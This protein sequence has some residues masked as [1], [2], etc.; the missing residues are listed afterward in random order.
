MYLVLLLPHVTKYQL[1]S[2]EETNHNLEKDLMVEK[3]QLA[4]QR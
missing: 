2:T 4:D 3:T 1:N